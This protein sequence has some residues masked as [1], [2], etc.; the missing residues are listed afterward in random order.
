M[1]DFPHVTLIILTYKRASEVRKC[2]AALIKHIIYPL[3]KMR[4]LIADDASGVENELSDLLASRKSKGGYPL[5]LPT[6]FTTTPENVGFGA[7]YNNAYEQVDTPYYFFIESDYILT[8]PL[9][10]RVGIAL[11]ETRANIGLLRYRGTAGEHVV[12][13]QFETDI[14]AYVPDYQEGVGLPGRLTYQQLDSGSPALYLWTNGAHL[15]HA[16][17]V[18]YYLPYPTSGHLGA[19]EEKMAHQVKDRMKTHAAPALAILPDWTAMWFDHIA[20]TYQ[21]TEDDKQWA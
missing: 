8:R 3:D 16:G 1:T 7:N 18:G 17:R 13:H 10:L 15:A 2:A 9:D 4:V 14:T 19:L 11:L 6:R 5:G 20:P 21:G 12:V